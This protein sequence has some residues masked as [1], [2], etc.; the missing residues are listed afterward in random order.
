AGWNLERRAA[1]AEEAVEAQ[2]RENDEADD[3][4]EGMTNDGAR[5]R[6]ADAYLQVGFL[7]GDEDDDVIEA[8]ELVEQLEELADELLIVGLDFDVHGHVRECLQNFSER[9]NHDALAPERERLATI[10]GETVGGV[11]RSEFGEGLA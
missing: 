10:R 9:R 4:R 11:E 2:A 7:G 6:V 1:G 5:L 3:F 8:L